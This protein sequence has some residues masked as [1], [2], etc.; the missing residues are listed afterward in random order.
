MGGDGG[1]ITNDRKFVRGIYKS[2][3]D[4]GKNLTQHQVL[5]SKL[6]AQSNQSLCEPI[7]A[8]EMGNLYNKEAMLTALI[9]KTLNPTHAHIRGLKDLK[10]LRFTPNPAIVADSD[11]DV[12]MFT[13]P[14]TGL[15]LNGIHPFVVIWTTGWVLSEKAIRELGIDAL[16]PEYGPFGVNDVI[17]L[18]PGE[19]EFVNQRTNMETRRESM[20]SEKKG[21]SKKNKRSTDSNNESNEHKKVKKPENPYVASSSSAG[22]SSSNGNGVA[23]RSNLTAASSLA[24][25]VVEAVAKQE[26][27][28]TLF[29]GLFHHGREADKKDKD[30][31]MTVAGLRYST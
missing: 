16:Q 14:V 19:E 1:T 26:E 10:T 18:I 17:K 7:V 30:L 11:D 8:C 3:E 23:S 29:A 31:F 12:P 13:C 28:N 22:G 9:D 6:C 27:S 2:D 20:K 4:K 21:D 15:L 5:R 25:Q 24:K